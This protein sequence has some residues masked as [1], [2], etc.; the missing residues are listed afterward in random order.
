[1]VRDDSLEG[2]RVAVLGGSRGLGELSAKIC[3]ARGAT[4]LITF[5]TGEADANAIADEIGPSCTVIR[6]D[7]GDL[8]DKE[9]CDFAPTDILY[10]VTP[11][12]SVKKG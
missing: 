1:M 6:W 9:I 12:I 7:T 8:E 10:Y 5:K 11:Y 4:V 2:R 3:A